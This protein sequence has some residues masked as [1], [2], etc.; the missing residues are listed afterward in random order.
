MS[1]RESALSLLAK[2]LEAR[3]NEP[4]SAADLAAALRAVQLRLAEVEHKASY[5]YSR[6]SP[7]G[8]RR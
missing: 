1:N 5:A 2:E 3:G 8:G 7:M 4:V 6:T